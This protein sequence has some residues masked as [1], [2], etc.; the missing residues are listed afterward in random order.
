MGRNLTRAPRRLTA[1]L[2]A[3]LCAA[4]ALSAGRRAAADAGDGPDVL[5]PGESATAILA[6]G[7]QRT[8]GFAAVAGSKW[9]LTAARAKHSTAAPTLAV[10]TPS[11]EPVD[12]RKLLKKSKSSASVRNLPTGVTGVWRLDVSTP[13]AGGGVVVTAAAKV[14]AKRTLKGTTA[15]DPTRGTVAFDALPGTSIDVSVRLLAKPPAPVAIRLLGPDGDDIVVADGLKGSARIAG[16][17]A[18]AVGTYTVE[19]VAAAGKFTASVRLKQPKRRTKLTV[20]DVEALPVVTAATPGTLLNGGMRTVYFSGFGFTPRQTAALDGDHGA[21]P[22][23]PVGVLPDGTAYATFNLIETQAGTYRARVFLSTGRATAAPAAIELSNMRPGITKLRP[24]EGPNAQPIDLIVDGGG[25]DAGISMQLRRVSDGV[26]LPFTSF[27]RTDHRTLTCTLTPAALQVGPHDIVFTDGDGTQTTVPAAFDLLGQRG[28]AAVVRAT[29]SGY[30]ELY[31]YHA[32]HDPVG[33]KAVIALLRN[34]SGVF[35]AEFVLVDTS[36]WSV[37]DTYTPSYSASHQHGFARVR[38]NHHDRTWALTWVGGSVGSQSGFLRV[39]S[40]GDLH[41]TV[42]DSVLVSDHYVDSVEPM[43]DEVAGGWMT[44]WTQA[45][46]SPGDGYLVVERV[47]ADGTPDT[48]SRRQVQPAQYGLIFFPTGAQRPDGRFVVTYIAVT[49]DITAY[50][51]SRRVLEADGSDYR[52]VIVCATSLEWYGMTE[53]NC[54][55]SPEDGTALVGFTYQDPTGTRYSTCF[56]LDGGLAEPGPLRTLSTEGHVDEGSF[57]AVYWSPT[58]REF[59]VTVLSEKKTV[60]LR[61]ITKSGAVHPAY[62]LQNYA[63][64]S[65]VTLSVP[66]AGTDQLHVVRAYEDFTGVPN[67]GSPPKRWVCDVIP[68]R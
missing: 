4:V 1:A 52:D 15:G 26:L 61:R 41:T 10:T 58:R 34:V 63:G 57:Q 2:A 7:D 65:G 3:A 12:L 23:V 33:G 8:V 38:F 9:N 17:V 53:P 32:A 56:T 6:P 46:K 39:A 19:V 51:L 67:D 42:K 28:P 66:G 50:T 11:G 21:T 36:T 5:L 49:G 31:V 48:A 37:L 60:I 43:A 55:V 68:I 59:V 29:T 20:D 64:R 45:P 35:R 62:V 30:D 25:F 54:S 47:A 16:V 40:A 44:A 13:L 18:P 27:R 14:P 22:R 24:F